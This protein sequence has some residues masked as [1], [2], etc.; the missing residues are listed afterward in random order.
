M[1][2]QD[3]TI[4]RKAVIQLFNSNSADKP[5]VNNNE[6]KSLLSGPIQDNKGRAKAEI[7]K[8]VQRVF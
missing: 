2:S 8:Q 4:Q 1:A 6:I 3:S 7:T 5:S